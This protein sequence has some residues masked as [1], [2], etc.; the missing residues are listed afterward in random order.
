MLGRCLPQS[1]DGADRLTQQRMRRRGWCHLLDLLDQAAG[2]PN[3][4][5]GLLRTRGVPSAAL[6]VHRAPDHPAVSRG[7]RQ[8]GG[9]SHNR[10]DASAPLQLELVQQRE[11]TAVVV[12]FVDRRRQRDRYR[13]TRPA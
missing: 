12:F 8:T 10:T 7:Q 2:E 11:D 4:V 9:L 3:C 5:Q 6:H 13:R 1:G